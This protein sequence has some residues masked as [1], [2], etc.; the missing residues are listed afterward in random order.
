MTFKNKVVLLTGS[1]GSWGTE[2]IAQLLKKGVKEIRGLARG[3]FNQVKL[4]RK[5][6]DSRLKIIIG[7]VRDYGKLKFA[8]KGVDYVF[9]LAAIKHVP[10]AEDFPYEAIKTNISGTRNLVRAA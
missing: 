6:N 7:D 10:L 5:F 8:C 1:S 4:S 2:L 3:E 9:H